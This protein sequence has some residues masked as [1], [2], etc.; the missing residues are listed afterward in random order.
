MKLKL[1]KEN[2]EKNK[3]DIYE[4]NL[5]ETKSKCSL[6]YE[7]VEGGGI[8]AVGQN[9]FMEQNGKIQSE[10]KEFDKK[11]DNHFIEEYQMLV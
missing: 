3:F 8:Y 1:V 10:Q 2:Y 4:M 7:N 6:L 5:E 11:S 9:L